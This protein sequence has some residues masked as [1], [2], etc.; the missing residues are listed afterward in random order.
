MSVRDSI[1]PREVSLARRPATAITVASAA[2]GGG[3]GGG[4]GSTRLRSG[5]GAAAATAATK[6]A[7]SKPPTPT[8]TVAARAITSGR[9]ER[10]ARWP[11]MSSSANTSMGQP[12]ASVA[13]S[14]ALD[15]R[16]QF[17]R[18]SPAA[19]IKAA[20]LQTNLFRGSGGGGGGSGS[21]GGGLAAVTR[22]RSPMARRG[23]KQHAA[24]QAA[25]RTAHVAAAKPR[26]HTLRASPVWGVRH[27][28][29]R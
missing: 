8:Q 29:C 1:A 14:E 22:R 20:S 17:T 2:R 9:V 13:V 28:Y 25:A 21:G 18:P 23:G 26:Y 10:A 6:P 24:S 27:D 12:A 16:W 4:G 7:A 15:T 5:I 19:E 3:G 11:S